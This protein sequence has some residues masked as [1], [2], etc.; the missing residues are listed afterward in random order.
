M[1]K[2][3]FIGLMLISLICLYAHSED[4][5][6]GN[7]SYLKPHHSFFNDMANKMEEAHYNAT[8]WEPTDEYNMGTTN[9]KIALLESS[10]IKSFFYDHITEFDTPGVITAISLHNLSLGNYWRF[11]AEFDNYSEII[12]R[13]T[14]IFTNLVSIGVNKVKVFL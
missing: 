6:I 12:Y 7:Y 9:N 1:K 3:L 11:E 2:L 13:K 14:F 4:F 8:I 10:G 5:V